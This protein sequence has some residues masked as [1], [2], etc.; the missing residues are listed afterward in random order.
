MPDDSKRTEL[1]YA[2]REQMV[3]EAKSL[4]TDVGEPGALQRHIHQVRL[5]K[6]RR[7]QKVLALALVILPLGAV[8]LLAG[9]ADLFLGLRVPGGVAQLDAQP[10]VHSRYTPLFRRRLQSRAVTSKRLDA[11][12]S[13]RLRR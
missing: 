3:A 13:E 7:M 5:L 2:T 11:I 10:D 4:A 1:R 12:L 9:M 6:H 8:A